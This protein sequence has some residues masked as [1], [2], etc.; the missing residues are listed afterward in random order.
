M[1]PRASY[2]QEIALDVAHW[3][4]IRAYSAPP[5][6]DQGGCAGRPPPQ[7]TPSLPQPTAVAG[8][9]RTCARHYTRMHMPVCPILP[10]ARRVPRCICTW[11][12][13]A[14]GPVGPGNRGGLASPPWPPCHS[15]AAPPAPPRIVV[16][17]LRV[18]NLAD[19]DR[20]RPAISGAA[21]RRGCLAHE[22][23][24]P[25]APQVP[26]DEGSSPRNTAGLGVCII[27]HPT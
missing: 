23:L 1:C 13:S 3:P 11:E 7:D 20:T 18:F 27:P 24:R 5:G 10:T 4:D 21:R 16:V 19:P 17:G 9:A 2:Y 14:L 12:S 8:W 26:R 6:G 22:A 15:P 25:G